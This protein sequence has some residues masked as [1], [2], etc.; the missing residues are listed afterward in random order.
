MEQR[1]S[2]MFVSKHKPLRRSLGRSAG[3]WRAIAVQGQSPNPRITI[4]KTNV[5]KSLR[6]RKDFF[7][8][9]KK[10]KETSV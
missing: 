5:Y 4:T 3:C 8:F 10:L 6:L 9:D 1:F 2:T 7:L